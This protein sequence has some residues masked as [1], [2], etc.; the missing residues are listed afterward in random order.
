VELFDP[1]RRPVNI[2]ATFI[3]PPPPDDWDPQ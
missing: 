3:V 2:L 1:S